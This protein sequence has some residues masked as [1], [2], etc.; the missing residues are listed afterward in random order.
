MTAA[1]VFPGSDA[2]PSNIA[3]KITRET[4]EVN[5]IFSAV[6]TAQQLRAEAIGQTLVDVHEQFEQSIRRSQ[7]TEQPVDDEEEFDD[8][9][10]DD[11]TVEAGEPAVQPSPHVRKLPV[12]PKSGISPVTGL[13]YLHIP[14]PAEAQAAR[15]VHQ[16]SHISSELANDEEAVKYLSSADPDLPIPNSL[17]EVFQ[18]SGTPIDDHGAPSPRVSVQ[19]KAVVASI[20]AALV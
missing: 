12:P 14:I 1:P 9:D 3:V 10:D 15:I 13:P 18:A 16:I 6:I 19:E 17:V 11:D 7:S 4:V 2:A 8:D 20:I 5:P